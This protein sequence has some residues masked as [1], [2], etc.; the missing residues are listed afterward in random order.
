MPIYLNTYLR[1]NWFKKNIFLQTSVKNILTLTLCSMQQVKQ[2]SWL[3]QG[4]IDSTGTE[5]PQIFSRVPQQEKKNL[6]SCLPLP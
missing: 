3:I 2:I 5:T 1:A 4:I 6:K